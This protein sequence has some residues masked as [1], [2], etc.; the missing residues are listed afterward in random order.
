MHIAIAVGLFYLNV[1]KRTFKKLHMY[2]PSIIYVILINSL[3]YFLFR[4]RLLWEMQSSNMGVST[5]KKFHL[6][7]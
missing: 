3:Y 2:Y 6:F 7:N 4:K 1:K 5:L